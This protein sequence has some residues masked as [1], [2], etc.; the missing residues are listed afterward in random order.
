MNKGGKWPLIIKPTQLEHVACGGQAK[1][2]SKGATKLKHC[3]YKAATY[4]GVE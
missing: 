4:G 2:T 3:K 1:I